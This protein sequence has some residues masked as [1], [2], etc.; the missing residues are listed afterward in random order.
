M[1]KIGIDNFTHEWMFDL[2]WHMVDLRKWFYMVNVGYIGGSAFLHVRVLGVRS[3]WTFPYF[4]SFPVKSDMWDLDGIME[5]LKREI[6][7]SGGVPAR[8]LQIKTRKEQ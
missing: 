8:Y 7:M 6:A 3:L 5:S 2:P 1:L 4:T